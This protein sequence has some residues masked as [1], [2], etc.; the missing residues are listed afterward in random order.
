MNTIALV[1]IF[2]GNLTVTSY[3]SVIEQ[4]DSSPYSTSIGE[5]VT[6]RGCAV[7]QD[8]LQNGVVH[9]G[10]LVYIES[11]GFRFINDSMNV[12]IKNSIDLWVQTKAEEKKIGTRHK[13][14]WLVRRPQI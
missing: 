11:Y 10:D 9:Y 6:I 3:R 13:R 5:R 7:S 14:V 12:R 8:L 4:T 1:M 2:I